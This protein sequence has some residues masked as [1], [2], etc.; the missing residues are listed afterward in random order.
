MSL[1]YP[2]PVIPV[3]GGVGKIF[4]V[5]KLPVNAKVSYY[6]NA[7]TPDLGADGSVQI[8]VQ[9]MFPK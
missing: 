2:L 8:Q 9:F 1:Q 7:E 6:H 4:R 3:G 5:G